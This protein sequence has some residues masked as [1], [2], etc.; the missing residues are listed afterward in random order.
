[1]LQ[2]RLKTVRNKRC[3]LG[4]EMWDCPYRWPKRVKIWEDRDMKG[5]SIPLNS[6]QREEWIF[7]ITGCSW[8][9]WK[10]TE[11]DRFVSMF[12]A[13][14]CSSKWNKPNPFCQVCCS[15][16]I[17]MIS[18]QTWSLSLWLLLLSRS[19]RYR[20]SGE[21]RSSRMLG[22]VMG[23]E[24]PTSQ[25]KWNVMRITMKWIKKIKASYTLE[26]T[27]LENVEHIKYIGLSIIND[28]RWIT[29]GSYVSNFC[30]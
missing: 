25:M 26:E 24:I 29:Y 21:Y 9:W 15:P 5:K 23:H 16:C 2:K 4:H 20:V 11:M 14:V 30:T 6:S 8:Y 3:G 7:I 12:Q 18:Q 19:Q 27:V 17:L 28:L 22:N 13:A 1:M 10:N